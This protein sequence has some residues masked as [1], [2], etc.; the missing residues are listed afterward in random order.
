MIF[1][2]YKTYTVYKTYYYKYCA[3]PKAKLGD[4]VLLTGNI[5]SYRQFY[6]VSNPVVRVLSSGEKYK[7]PTAVE[8]TATLLEDWKTKTQSAQFIVATGVADGSNY[9]AVTVDGYTISPYQTS[10]SFKMENY[11]GK[12]VTIKGYTA[13]LN[14]TDLRII[15]T[16]VEEVK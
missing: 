14:G 15:V 7:L 16:S 2:C 11:Y 10:S 8:P 4:K 12:N 3:E 13:Q 9:G 6:Q 5:S 1:R